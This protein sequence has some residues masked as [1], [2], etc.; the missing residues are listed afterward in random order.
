M[1]EYLEEELIPTQVPSCLPAST[2]PSIVTLSAA[3]PPLPGTKQALAKCVPNWLNFSTFQLSP[4][5]VMHPTQISLH[6]APEAHMIN[7]EEK[8]FLRGGG[9]IF[10]FFLIPLS[11]S[12]SC[13]AVKHLS[14]FSPLTTS[15]FW[16]IPSRP[17]WGTISKMIN[18]CLL[19][20]WYLKVENFKEKGFYTK[21]TINLIVF[22]TEGWPEEFIKSVKD[23]M[24]IKLLHKVNTLQRSRQ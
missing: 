10:F 6:S 3:P 4:P 15:H 11:P 19:I 7:W 5:K 9:W 18:V 17:T 14:Y 2:P 12:L 13:S 24:Y 20:F 1:Q 8:S 21:T 22:T 23:L 16:L